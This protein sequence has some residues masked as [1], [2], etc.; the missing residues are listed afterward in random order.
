M[1][2]LLCSPEATSAASSWIGTS[3]TAVPYAATSLSDWVIS[4]QSKRKPDDGVGPGGLGHL[5]EPVD[6]VLAG[7]GQHGDVAVD[8]V[9]AA[10][11]RSQLTG[12]GHHADHIADHLGDLP[13][14][15]TGP[16]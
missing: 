14:R 1:T 5:G 7:L 4:L 8:R 16:W 12:A 6:R 15:D 11:I 13:A 3:L 9:A 10:Q 2:V